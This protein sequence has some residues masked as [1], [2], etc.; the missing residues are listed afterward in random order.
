MQASHFLLCDGRLAGFFALQ[1][2]VALY[3][4]GHTRRSWPEKIRVKP[5]THLDWYVG[6][7]NN[8]SLDRCGLPCLVVW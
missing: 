3:V 6:L 4:L 5:A 8:R 7:S 1:H 2:S